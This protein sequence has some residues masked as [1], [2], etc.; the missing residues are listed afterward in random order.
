MTTA[1]TPSGV[2]S[3]GATLSGSYAGATLTVSEVGFYYGT[4]NNPSTKVA[5]E[6]T[7]SSFSKAL[8][9]LNSNT[10]YYYKAYVI[11]GGEER[12]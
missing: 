8:T 7:S 3:T 6:G 9:G 1:N 2:S 10:T 5:A 12:L 11:E 4:T